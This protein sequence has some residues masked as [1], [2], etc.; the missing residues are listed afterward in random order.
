MGKRWTAIGA[1]LALAGALAGLG[2]VAGPL[3]AQRAP[4]PAPGPPRGPGSPPLTPLG[5]GP[6]V[7]A[8]KSGPVRAEVVARG[9]D[10][11]WGVAFAGSSEVLVTERPGRLRLIRDGALVPE[12]IAGVPANGS[13]YDVALDPQFASNRLLYLAYMK[14]DPDVPGQRTLAVARAR[15][16]GGPSLADVSDILVTLPWLGAQP[17]PKRCCGQGPAGASLGGRLAFDATGRLLVASSDRDYGELVQDPANDF[18]KILRI[19]TDGSAPPD[20]PFVGMA[21]HDPKIWTLGH[22]NTGGLFFDAASGTTWESEF[23]PEGGDELNRIEKGRNYGWILVTQGRHYDG[24]PSLKGA[25]DVPGMT[26]PVLA[27]GPPSL[28]PSDVMVYRGTR[29]AGWNGDLF[30]ATFTQALLHFRFDADGHPV[31]EDKLLTGLNQRLRSVRTAP[32]G[33]LWVLTDETGGAVL[34]LV[35]G[36]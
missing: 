26:D 29:F 4:P 9:L 8:T 28:N 22:R 20:N 10:H 15:W 7:L 25:R 2:S 24:T 35:P 33:S 11:P 18:G 3:M 36:D 23:G 17:W 27:F 32:D 13:L 31:L 21:G 34:R 14:R 30:L 1:G 6:W 19:D 16:D 12:P 5:E